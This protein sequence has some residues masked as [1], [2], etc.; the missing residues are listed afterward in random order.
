MV[1]PV[2]DHSHIIQKHSCAKTFGK[3]LLALHL[4][5][6]SKLTFLVISDAVLVAPTVQLLVWACLRSFVRRRNVVTW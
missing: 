4:A 3:Y 6:V 2:K 1:R 5:H